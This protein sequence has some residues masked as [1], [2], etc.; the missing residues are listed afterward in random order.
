MGEA[1]SQLVYQ[2]GSDARSAHDEQTTRNAIVLQVQGLR[3]AVSGVS[4]DEEAVEMLKFQRAY[5]AN[6]K[7]FTTIND[8]ISTLMAM[9]GTP[10]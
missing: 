5:E 4:L 10:A 1:W 9:V 7:M 2:V 8:T 3:D 6:A